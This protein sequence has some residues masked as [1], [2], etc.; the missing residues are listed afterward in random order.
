MTL[1]ERLEAAETGSRELDMMVLAALVGDGAYVEQSRFNGAWCVYCENG[2]L[3]EPNR[4]PHRIDLPRNQ[5]LFCPTT[6]IDAALTMLDEWWEYE[7]TTLY[8]IAHVELPL[9]ASDI[10][11]QI[12][13][14]KDDNVPL[15]LCAANLRAREAMKEKSDA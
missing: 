14:R 8:G 3:W 1:I 5:S 6:S 13:R 9:N 4:S 15:A 12:G 11:P 7:I 2:D 10:D